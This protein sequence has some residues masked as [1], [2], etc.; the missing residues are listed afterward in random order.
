MKPCRC[1]S[2][3]TLVESSQPGI[4]IMRLECKCGQHGATLLYTKPQ[5]RA[6]MA[7]AAWDGWNL[8]DS[9]AAIQ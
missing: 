8:S 9:F 4:R 7:Q 1:G 6:R 5:D 3:P 2:T